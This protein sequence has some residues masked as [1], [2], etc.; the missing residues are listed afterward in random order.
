M[1]ETLEYLHS[2]LKSSIATFCHH[3]RNKSYPAGS[4]ALQLALTNMVYYQL[5]ENEL[6]LI[7]DHHSH[8]INGIR[9]YLTG[10]SF[11]D[12]QES[13]NQ[14][15][16]EY[17]QRFFSEVDCPLGSSSD[18]L[19]RWISTHADRQQLTR[20]SFEDYFPNLEFLFSHTSEEGIDQVRQIID[21]ELFNAKARGFLRDIEASN[22][23][24]EFN[25]RMRLANR[26]LEANQSIAEVL[27]VIEGS[28]AQ[29]GNS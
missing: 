16:Y 22:A 1:R 24:E 12:Y 13:S 5:L 2:D 28:H 3:L 17:C 29:S 10:H 23:L 26:M 18:E 8:V 9:L 15:I 7:L 19:T 11:N 4:D 27:V 21:A 20:E 6:G 14:S 25:Q